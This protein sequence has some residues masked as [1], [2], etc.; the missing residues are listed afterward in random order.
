VPIG[1]TPPTLTLSQ[2]QDGI[3]LAGRG[4]VAETFDQ[5][6]AS[7][8]LIPASQALRATGI[9]LSAGQVVT[10][11]AVCVSTAGTALTHAWLLL[12]NPAQGLVAQSAD[13]PAS[14]AAAGIVVLPMTSPFTVPTS[15]V[16]YAAWL[17]AIG[18]TMPTFAATAGQVGTAAAIGAGQIRGGAQLGQAAPPNPATITSAGFNT[19]LWYAV[20]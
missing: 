4:I 3:L 12:Y 11:M 20:L 6:L 7:A 9:P 8:L 18:T 19:M 2:T 15:G 13:T 16:Y 17:G 14:F 10:S 1:S 5:A